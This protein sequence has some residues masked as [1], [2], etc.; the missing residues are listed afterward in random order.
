MLP[1]NPSLIGSP[2]FANTIGDYRCSLFR[3]ECGIGITYGDYDRDLTFDEFSRKRRK[4]IVLTC[5]VV[6][7]DRNALPFNVASLCKTFAKRSHHVIGIALP[8]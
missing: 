2:P 3:R 7:F 1:T 5:Y 4:T 8:K 6:Y